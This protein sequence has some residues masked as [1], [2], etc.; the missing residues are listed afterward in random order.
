MLLTSA[1]IVFSLVAGPAD[2]SSALLRDLERRVGSDGWLTLHQAVGGEEFFE[3]LGSNETWLR[4]ILD[5]GPVRRPEV[6]LGFLLEVWQADRDLVQRPVDRGMATAC[7]LALGFRDGDSARMVERYEYYRDSESAGLLNA[8][9]KGLATW[10]RRFLARGAQWGNMADTDS[11][12]YLR[13]RICWPRR[14]YVRACW[15]A[16][17][18]SFNCL[19][20]SVQ[21]PSYYMPFQ[22]S[23]EAMPEMVIEVGGVCGALSNLGAS[24]AMANGIPAATMGE[25]GHCAYTVK[26]SDTEWKPAYSLSW[27]R[28]LHTKFYDG[29]WQSL[30]LTEACFSDSESVARAADLA[31]A[32]HALEQEGKLDKANDQWAK[33]LKAHGLHYG[34]WMAW[35]DFGERTAQDT[36]WWAR[37]QNAL[38]DGLQGHEGPAWGILSKRVY[39]KLFAELE[40]AAK[41]RTLLKWI[42]NQDR[43]GAGRWNVE[44]AWDWAF[45]QLDGKSQS[46]LESTMCNILISSPDFGPPLVAWLLG[47]HDADSAEGKAT[48]ARIL[49]ASSDGGE[50]GSAVL[51]KLARSALL[52]AAARGDVPTFQ[53]IGA[54]TAR[55]SEPK[56]MSGIKP[57]PGDLVSAGGLLQVSGRGNRWDTPETHWGIL[58][59]HGG[60]C[61]TDNGASFIAVRLEHHTEITGIV[62]QNVTGGQAWRAAGSRVEIST[63]GET[64]EQVGVLEGTKRFYSLDLE[65]KKHRALWVRMA[66]D[67]NCLHVTRFLVWGHRRS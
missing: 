3:S 23:F 25:P 6:V 14:E 30:M 40:D 67:T 4:E 28:S 41:L 49:A 5:S 38:L 61:H 66:K 37:Y 22:G 20:D 7:A 54:Q 45:K 24:A 48:L 46:K 36:A 47:K 33:A 12:V 59:E 31:R 43:W 34:L 19:D 52:D 11:L 13:D 8:C 42:R 58:G 2:D 65:A 32:A 29:T 1:A 18:R 53:I 44:G 62:I 60:R 10:E 27:K 57:F 63:D 16:P 50:G 15:Q 26:I 17:Y 51:K 39:P 55:L 56:D 21:R 64:W 35:A 9:Y